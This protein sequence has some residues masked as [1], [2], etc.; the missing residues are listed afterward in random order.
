M[1]LTVSLIKADVGSVG[2]H[3]RP[4]SRML[5]HVYDRLEQAIEDGTLCDAYTCYTG[6]DIALL[7]THQY[8][9][10]HEKIHQFAW[11]TFQQAG[12]I[13]AEQGLY[14]AGQDL[15]ADAPSGN[16]RGAGP[17]VAEMEITYGEGATDRP[18]ESFLMFAADKCGPGLFNLPL[19]L[20]FADPMFCSGLMLPKMRAGF[21]F[22]LVDMEYTEG[23]RTLTLHAPEDYYKIPVLLRDNERFGIERIDSRAYDVPVASVS[24][25]RLHAIAGKYVGKDDPVALVRTQHIFPAPEELLSP[26]MMAHYVGGDARG[27][28]VMPVMPV[29]IN[30]PVS[31]AYCMPILSC[32]A[33]SL[34]KNGQFA[35]E[36]VDMFDNPAWDHVRQRAQEKAWTMRQQG[37][38]GPAMLPHSELEYSGFNDAICD[39][40]NQFEVKNED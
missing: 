29:A 6:D 9:P 25:Q 31:S 3:T 7:M 27:S 35:D 22:H 23:K 30:T 21:S 1:K 28:H 11:D 13:A 19:F 16:V 36:P 24:S 33:F 37:W 15:L 38:S 12:E 32:L 14:G 39:L 4:S 10:D 17:G 2:G 26:Y 8:G 18:V 34:D 40:V 5:E 20:G